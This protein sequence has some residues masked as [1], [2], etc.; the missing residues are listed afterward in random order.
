MM[1]G[2]VAV[3]IYSTGTNVEIVGIAIPNL[4]VAFKTVVLGIVPALVFIV[5]LFVVWLELDELRIESELKIE[6]RRARKK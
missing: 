4:W 3:V 5:G 6:T 1:V 2:S